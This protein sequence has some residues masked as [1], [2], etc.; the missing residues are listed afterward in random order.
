MTLIIC[1]GIAKTD[2]YNKGRELKT[3]LIRHIIPAIL[4]KF[5]F[6]VLSFALF[7]DNS[8]FQVESLLGLAPRGSPRYLTGKV[9]LRQK[10]EFARLEV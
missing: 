7:V 4:K 9:S 5:S 8:G 1:F 6:H 3:D 10:T 2:M